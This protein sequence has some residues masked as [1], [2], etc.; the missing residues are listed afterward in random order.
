[1]SKHT[2]G[3]PAGTDK[4]EAIASARAQAK[5]DGYVTDPG[6]CSA[7]VVETDAHRDAGEFVVVV[8]PGSGGIG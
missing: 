1:M 3:F 6:T 5:A 7:E 8:R 4:V 2:Y